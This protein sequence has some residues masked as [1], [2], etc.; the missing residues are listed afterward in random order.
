MIRRTIYV[1]RPIA[2]GKWLSEVTAPSARI[3][4]RNPSDGRFPMTEQQ[5]TPL[6]RRMIDD[7]ARRN[8]SPLT[9]QAY[10]RA[11][12]NFGLFFRRSP[13]KLNFEDV[14]TYQLH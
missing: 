1:F 4:G 12:K 7:M 5:M 2:T 9:Q 10:V 11:V 6:R 13:D 8:M 14:R 3:A